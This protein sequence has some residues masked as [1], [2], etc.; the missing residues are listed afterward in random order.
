MSPVVY[1]YDA[2]RN[3]DQQT[4]PGVP[5]ADLTEDFL[6]ELS[7]WLRKS[8]AACNFYVPAAVKQQRGSLPRPSETKA[9]EA[10]ASS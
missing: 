7:D 10:E 2:E 6:A 8:I 5:L 3:P 4:L 1:V 9:N